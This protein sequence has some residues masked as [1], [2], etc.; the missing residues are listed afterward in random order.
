MIQSEPCNSLSILGFYVFI[1]VK[2]GQIEFRLLIWQWR[3]R[4]ITP[5]TLGIITKV[6]GTTCA[7]LTIDPNLKSDELHKRIWTKVL[8]TSGPNL[9]IPGWMSDDLWHG[10]AQGWHI[11]ADRDAG[12]DNTRRPILAW[13]K[14]A[15]RVLAM[16]V[17]TQ[18][19]CGNIMQST[20]SILRA[21]C[22]RQ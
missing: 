7:H 12:S 3:L 4:F 16:C 2:A 5:Q 10:Q 21:K 13:G 1:L 19:I 11:Q 6:F 8:Y 14:N 20:N 9:V 17:Q 22:T 15:S 18:M